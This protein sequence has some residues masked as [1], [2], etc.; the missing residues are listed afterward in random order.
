MSVQ[1]CARVNEVTTTTSVR[2]R[3]SG[4]AMHS[5]KSRWSGPLSTWPTPGAQ[6]RQRRLVPARIELHDAGVAVPL[7]GAHARRR[8]VTRRSTVVTRCPSRRT[9]A[10]RSPDARPGPGAGSR[11]ARRAR[12]VPTA[13]AWRGSSGGPASWARAVSKLSNARSDGSDSRTRGQRRRAPGCGRPRGCSMPCTSH[14]VAA[15]R[16]AGSTRA[17][18]DVTGPARSARPRRASRRAARARAA[19]RGPSSGCRNA[20]TVM[21]SGTSWAAVVPPRTNR[22]AATAART[23][24]LTE[25][26]A[27]ASGL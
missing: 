25:T 6:E 19:R 8:R 7:E 16:S 26:S 5:R 12:P 1:A 21:S 18:I 27:K 3:R 4:M 9:S 13:A 14:T 17:E 23:R 15:C 24:V 20:C 10:R 2:M 11:C 22:T